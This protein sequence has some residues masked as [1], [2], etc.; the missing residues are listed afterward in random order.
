MNP[1]GICS[2]DGGLPWRICV[3]PPGD[4]AQAHHPWDRSGRSSSSSSSSS[5][6]PP[7]PSDP[8]SF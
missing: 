2:K 8:P 3:G 6:N 1:P 4:D 5:S 7:S